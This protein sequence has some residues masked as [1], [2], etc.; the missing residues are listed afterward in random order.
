MATFACNPM[1]HYTV[2]LTMLLLQ[3]WW[4]CTSCQG[5][6]CGCPLSM[7]LTERELLDGAVKTFAKRLFFHAGIFLK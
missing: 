7:E 5:C 2:F 1:N 6:K 3:T 4:S